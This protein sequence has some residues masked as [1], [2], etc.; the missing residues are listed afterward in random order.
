MDYYKYGLA[1]LLLFLV[2]Y[3]GPPGFSAEEVEATG[4]TEAALGLPRVGGTAAL[5]ATLPRWGFKRSLLT[6]STL[7]PT[8]IFQALFPLSNTL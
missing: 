7:F 1:D 3:T 5:G 8:C 2:R 6:K 4:A